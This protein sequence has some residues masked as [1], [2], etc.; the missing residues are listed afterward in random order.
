MEALDTLKNGDTLL[1][2]G[3]GLVGA[4]LTL[5]DTLKEK[6]VSELTIV[7][8]NLGE[9]VETPIPKATS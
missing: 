9:T 4:P 6:E 8:N 1:V 5:I 3:F 7:S 2:V